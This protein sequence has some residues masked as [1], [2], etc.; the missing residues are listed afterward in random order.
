MPHSASALRDV[1]QAD[2]VAA[3]DELDAAQM[4]RVDQHAAGDDARLRGVN[5]V[6]G[7]AF[8]GA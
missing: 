3:L 2:A 1:V 5:A 7:G 4:R 6:A 8:G